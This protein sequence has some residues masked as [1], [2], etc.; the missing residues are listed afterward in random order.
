[1]ITVGDG[2]FSVLVSTMFVTLLMV[3]GGGLGVGLAVALTGCTVYR[4]RHSPL[5][6]ARADGA[7][8]RNTAHG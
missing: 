7:F 5:R 6:P 1:V 2:F 3:A 4:A 8:A